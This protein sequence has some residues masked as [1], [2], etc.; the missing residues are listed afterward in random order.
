M[1]VLN[2]LK[3]RVARGDEYSRAERAPRKGCGAN[4]KYIMTGEAVLKCRRCDGGW[5]MIACGGGW[6]AQGGSRRERRGS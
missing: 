1:R 4:E 3:G 5:S 2:F 6:L